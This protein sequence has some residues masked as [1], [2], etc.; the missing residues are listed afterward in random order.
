MD[1]VD[2]SM[3]LNDWRDD[4]FMCVLAS[5]WS[6][7]IKLPVLLWL[8]SAGPQETFPILRE[9]QVPILRSSDYRPTSNT[10]HVNLTKC[11]S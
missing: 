5:A 9:K 3:G 8:F 10:D 7:K 4:N 2:C 1:L 6:G 11:I